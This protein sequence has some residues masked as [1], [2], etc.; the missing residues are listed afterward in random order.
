MASF[1]ILEVQDTTVKCVVTLDDG[2]TFDQYVRGDARY[3]MA[4]IAGAVA[5]AAATFEPAAVPKPVTEQAV[6]DAVK[7]RTSIDLAIA[8][9]GPIL[10]VP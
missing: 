5:I 6:M 2:V 9:A 7:Q 3:S 10:K 4:G 8:I 1:V